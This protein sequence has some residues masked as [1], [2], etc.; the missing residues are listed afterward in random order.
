MAKKYF[1]DKCGKELEGDQ[2]EEVFEEIGES[3]GF[4]KNSLIAPQLCRSCKKGYERII[5]ET[6]KKIKEYLESE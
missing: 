3:F 1:C 6:N 5:K 2:F 4:N